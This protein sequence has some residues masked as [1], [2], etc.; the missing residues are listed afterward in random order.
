MKNLLMLAVAM[1]MTA[2]I[3]FAAQSTQTPEAKGKEYAKGIVKAIV[4]DDLEKIEIISENMGYYVV[5]LSESQAVS[6]FEGFN[7]GIYYY[8]DYY[9]LGEDA[10]DVFLQNF[11]AAMFAELD[12]SF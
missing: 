10:A 6:F 5:Q 11:Y 4:D 7:D 1:L 8:C 3:A 2:A 12:K 9:G